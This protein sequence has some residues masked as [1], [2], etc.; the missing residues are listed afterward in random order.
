[1]VPVGFSDT[2]IIWFHLVMI[3]YM[4]R[5][6]VLRN[7]NSLFMLC[8]SPHLRTTEGTNKKRSRPYRFSF[9]TNLKL[10]RFLV[11]MVQERYANC[12]WA[13]SIVMGCLLVHL[14]DVVGKL[15]NV[16]PLSSSA[17]TLLAICLAS[18]TWTV[19]E[20]FVN[21]CK[22]FFESASNIVDHSLLPQ[23][24]SSLVAS[25]IWPILF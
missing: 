4:N 10:D 25:N 3:T 5:D 16:A 20:F 6:L 2:S 1:M 21:V 9:L 14:H 18:L 12:H 11:D 8:R 13:W 7:C 24:E 22:H 17:P 15:S 23:Q 19:L